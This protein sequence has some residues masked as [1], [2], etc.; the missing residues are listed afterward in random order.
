[1]AGTNAVN[2]YSPRI[3]QSLGLNASSAKLFATGVY[4]IVRFVATLIAM[5]AFTDRFGRV[6]MI[7]WGGSIM[8][9]CMWVVGVLIK[10]YP[11]VAGAAISAGQY[12]AIVL[13]FVW[14]VAFCFSVSRDVPIDRP[15][16]LS[17][18]FRRSCS[19]PVFPGSIARK[20][21]LSESEPSA[22]HFAPPLTGPSI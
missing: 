2:Y 17:L 6:T 7:V 9:A 1:M 19:M 21:S 5:V 14:A 3:F 15:S 8:A 16:L 22:W 18:T 4:G 13:I 11:P 10:T 20:S 12:A